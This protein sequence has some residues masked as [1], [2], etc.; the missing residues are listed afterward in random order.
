MYIWIIFRAIVVGD[1]LIG[2]LKDRGDN[3]AY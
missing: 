3:Y 1:A 2:F